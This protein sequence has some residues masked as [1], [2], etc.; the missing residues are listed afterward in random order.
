MR[1]EV[2]SS[3]VKKIKKNRRITESAVTQ[4]YGGFRRD[5]LVKGGGGG[6][7]VGQAHLF[8]REKELFRDGTASGHVEVNV[9]SQKTAI[10]KANHWIDRNS[11]VWRFYYTHNWT[12]WPVRPGAS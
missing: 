4:T 7:G 10:K 6:G 5:A 11:N 1:G 8:V 3:L 2:S 12:R 9:K